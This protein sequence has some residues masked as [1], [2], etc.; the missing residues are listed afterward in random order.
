MAKPV[1]PPSV[2][3]TL[4]QP[5]FAASANFNSLADPVARAS[6]VVFDSV[7]KLR[8]RDWR[9]KQQYTYGLLGTP[10]SRRLERQLAAIDGVEHALLFPSGLSAISTLLLAFLKAGDQ[11]LMPLNSYVPALDTARLLQQRFGIELAFYDPMQLDTLK[12]AA[13]TRLLWVE[14]PG[15]VTMEV[16]DLPAL[17]ALAHQH[18]VLVAIDATWAAGIALPVF[19]LGADLSIQALTKYQSGGSDV[20]MGCVTTADEGLYRTLSETVVSLGIGVSPEDCRLILRSLPHYRLRYLAQD[21]A[22]R[23]VAQWLSQHPAVAHVLHPALPDAPGHAI[24]ARDFTAAAS[25]FSVVFREDIQ[26]PALDRCVEALQLFHLGFSW[27]GAVSLVVPFTRNQ[28]HAAYSYAGLLV[29]FYIGLEDA[30]DL[31][32]DLAQALQP[33][34]KR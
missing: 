14:T 19:E 28:M 7:E 5:D 8:Q 17:A 31:I 15:S 27:G 32:Q 29:R 22:A 16:A 25:L 13:N 20:L 26:Q 24:W 21:Q 6:T 11:V 2:W 9:D 30:Q 12:F 4:V 3:T 34:E 1:T 18:E 10:T 23:Q 33:L